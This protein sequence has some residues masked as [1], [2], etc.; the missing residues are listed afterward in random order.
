LPLRNFVNLVIEGK[1][2]LV[3]DVSADSIGALKACLRD[4]ANR[5]GASL[6]LGLGADPFERRRPV[7]PSGPEPNVITRHRPRVGFLDGWNLHRFVHQAGDKIAAPAIL[8]TVPL[9]PVK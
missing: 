7:R 9:G 5:D 1:L 8:A 4:R 6:L 3:D 2:S